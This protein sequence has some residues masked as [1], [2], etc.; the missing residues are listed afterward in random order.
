MHHSISII[1]LPFL[2]LLIK[3]IKQ[4]YQIKNVI[5]SDLQFT[6]TYPVIYFFLR[7]KKDALSQLETMLIIIRTIVMRPTLTMIPLKLTFTIEMHHYSLI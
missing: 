6:Q 3:N 4:L 2:V 7:H 1:Q 5:C